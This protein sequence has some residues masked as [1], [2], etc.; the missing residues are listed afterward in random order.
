LVPAA[1]ASQ[2]PPSSPNAPALTRH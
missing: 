1:S 2:V